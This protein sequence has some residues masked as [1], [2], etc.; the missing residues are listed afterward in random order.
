M[1]S[2]SQIF[3]VWIVLS[4]T[5]RPVALILT[6]SRWGC[7][8]NVPFRKARRVSRAKDHAQPISVLIEKR[9]ST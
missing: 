1:I 5:S 8:R 2:S 9:C 6:L 7:A 3:V 4:N